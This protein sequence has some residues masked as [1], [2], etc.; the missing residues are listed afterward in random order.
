MDGRQPHRV[1]GDQRRG[2]DQWYDQHHRAERG[3]IDQLLQRVNC[4]HG[5][6]P[7]GHREHF[8]PWQLT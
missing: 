7:V 3:L 5:R 8:D 1:G 6:D 4:G 2:G